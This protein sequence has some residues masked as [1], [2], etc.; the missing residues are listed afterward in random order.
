MVRTIRVASLKPNSKIK[1]WKVEAKLG[2]GSYGEVWKAKH[3]MG[4][5]VAIKSF[6]RLAQI[7]RQDKLLREILR[8]AIAMARIQHENVVAFNTDDIE[9]GCIVFE[10]VPNSL[11]QEIKRRRGTSSW[12]SLDEA[13]SIFK[14]ILEGLAAIHSK[15][16]VHGDI[17]PANILLTGRLTPKMSDFGMAS[18]LSAKKFPCS[19][20]H[21]S[22]N[23]AASEVLLGEKPDFQSDLFSVGIIAYLLFTGQHPFYRNDPTCL[24]GPEDYISNPDYQI[25]SARE[26]NNNIL[27]PISDI[28]DKL[29]QRDRNERYK[30]VQEVL[31]A[32]TE[33]EAPT[34]PT[35]IEATRTEVEVTSEIGYSIVE[36]KR[37]FHTEF[38]PPAALKIL[39][40]IIDKFKSSNVRFLANAFS[41]K[42]FIHNYLQEWE[43]SIKAATDGITLDPTHCDSYMARGY[44]YKRKGYQTGDNKFL[45]CAKEDLNKAKL[46]APDYR[47][48]QQAQK[49]LFELQTYISYNISFDTI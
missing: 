20:F 7:V 46:L 30:N 11:E 38:N 1:D 27:A 43:E 24:S 41:Y 37:L 47:K 32:L 34:A 28:I 17:K 31:M 9:R 19:F 44:A 35:E 16:I 18:I 12:F 49:H 29:L 5:I 14:G 48:R 23:W 25:K 39:T 4:S 22:N 42:A 45:E 26:E 40:D 13:L 2:S 36:A 21:G 10:F 3:Q 6:A 33:L 8:E 15:Q